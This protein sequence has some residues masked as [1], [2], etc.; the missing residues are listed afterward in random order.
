MVCCSIAAGWG[1][2]DVNED[3]SMACTEEWWHTDAQVH[4][5]D[6]TVSIN[7]NSTCR[8]G[9]RERKLTQPAC[10]SCILVLYSF[11]FT[12]LQTFW[13][14]LFCFIVVVVVLL[15][16]EMVGT[17]IANRNSKFLFL[18]IFKILFYFTLTTT[19]HYTRFNVERHQTCRN[20]IVQNIE[21]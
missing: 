19:T 16:G 18:L 20:T 3:V 9:G 15:C 21:H 10:L 7:M 6:K 1:E 14:G 17:R 11:T 4:Y 13:I 8:V 5:F 12:W 2:T